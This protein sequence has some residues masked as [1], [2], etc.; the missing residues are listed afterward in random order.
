ML[1]GVESGNAHWAFICKI[2]MGKEMQLY[3]KNPANKPRS[4]NPGARA[5]ALL[6]SFAV[7]SKKIF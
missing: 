3:S 5:L 6:S 1:E 2:Y 7:F 4:L